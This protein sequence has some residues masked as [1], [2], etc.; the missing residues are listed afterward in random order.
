M[1]RYDITPCFT[2]DEYRRFEA[3]VKILTDEPFNRWAKAKV[4]LPE[5]TTLPSHV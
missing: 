2:F 4:L 1:T 3:T 5:G